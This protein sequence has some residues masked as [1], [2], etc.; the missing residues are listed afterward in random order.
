MVEGDNV[1]AAWTPPV[2]ANLGTKKRC[3]IKIY[4]KKLFFHFEILTCNFL[5]Y[6]V[7]L[8]IYDIFQKCLGAISHNVP[9]VYDGLAARIRKCVA[10]SGPTNCAGAT[11]WEWSEAE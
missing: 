6:S 8:F 5:I 9:A 3:F 1:Q 10:F 2:T 4:P 7:P 11:A